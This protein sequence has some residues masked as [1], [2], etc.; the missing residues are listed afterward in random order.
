MVFSK[1]ATR[2]VST[3]KHSSRQGNKITQFIIHA[4]MGGGDESN[5]AYLSTGKNDVSASYVLQTTG[6]LVGVVPE[7]LRPWTTG[8]QADKNAVTV[9]TVNSTGAPNW[10]VTEAQIQKLAELA[11]DLCKRYGWGRL[12]RTRIRAHREFMNTSCPG[13]YLYSKFGEI[14]TRANQILGKTITA[15]AEEEETEMIIIAQRK[16]SQL[17]KGIYDPKT[18]K[19]ARE[20]KPEENNLLRSAEGAGGKANGTIL[21]GTVSDSDYAKLLKK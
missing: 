15:T 2:T 13:D 18:G 20:I 3:T 19:I 5:V 14:I 7:E 8:W 10:L 1:L 4:T 12:D 9:E 11:A 17:A 21:Y 6:N 16:N